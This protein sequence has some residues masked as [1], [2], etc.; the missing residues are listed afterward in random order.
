MQAAEWADGIWEGMNY[1]V[2]QG[3]NKHGRVDGRYEQD[4]QISNQL[5]HNKKRSFTHPSLARCSVTILVPIE[6]L[7]HILKSKDNN[8]HHKN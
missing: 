2:V 4:S 1:Q 7:K 8:T 3:K 5:D 6:N